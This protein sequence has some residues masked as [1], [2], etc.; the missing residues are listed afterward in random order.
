MISLVPTWKRTRVRDLIA[1]GA[2]FK[3]SRV[4]STR[5][6]ETSV[7]GSPTTSPRAIAARSSPWRLTAVRWPACAEATAWPC[8]CNPRI[9]ASVLLG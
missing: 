4:P 7:P 9:L 3:S 2:S 5:S 8:A 6:V 1:R